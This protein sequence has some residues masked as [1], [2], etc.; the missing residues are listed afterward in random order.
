MNMFTREDVYKQLRLLPAEERVEMTDK[1][2]AAG[3]NAELLEDDRVR[4]TL[5]RAVP[6]IPFPIGWTVTYT[7]PDG[8]F[9][10]FLVSDAEEGNASV[11]LDMLNDFGVY[12]SC[13]Y[14]EAYGFGEEPDR[15]SLTDV[16][17]LIEIIRRQMQSNPPEQLG[18][19]FKAFGEFMHRNLLPPE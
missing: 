2:L 5:L 17:G 18:D 6:F 1:L 9:L 4:E 11:Y 10:R 8:A 12:A 19:Y 15:C 7:E 16:R 13:P 14:W 3:S